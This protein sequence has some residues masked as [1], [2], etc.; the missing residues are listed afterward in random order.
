VLCCGRGRTVM[1]GPGGEVRSS[2]VFRVRL[3]CWVAQRRHGTTRM[4]G[5][6]HRVWSCLT[7]PSPRV[8][9]PLDVVL[10]HNQTLVKWSDRTRR[11]CVQSCAGGAQ[12]KALR[13]SDLE[14]SPVIRTRPRSFFV[15]WNLIVF[16]RTRV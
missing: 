2:P 15:L 11:M 4:I 1:T 9:G 5:P 8:H 16:G 7:G 6:R 10:A 3:C 12:R 14:L 13:G